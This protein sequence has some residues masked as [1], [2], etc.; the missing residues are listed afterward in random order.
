MDTY[1]NTQRTHPST[2]ASQPTSTTRKPGKRQRNAVQQP[3]TQQS[4]SR[5]KFDHFQ[6]EAIEDVEEEEEEEEE[7]E[8]A[9]VPRSMS[10]KDMYRRINEVKEGCCHRCHVIVLLTCQ[11]V[12]SSKRSSSITTIWSLYD[13]LNLNG[14]T[15][16]MS[17]PKARSL[18]VKTLLSTWISMFL[19][20]CLAADDC[21]KRME[22]ELEQLSRENDELRE[23]LQH[24]KPNRELV[25]QVDE[26]N[27][28]LT[29]ISEEKEALKKAGN[30]HYFQR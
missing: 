12:H 24:S 6:Q 23:K 4:A 3:A 28:E 13:S 2:Y 30:K 15:R 10:L 21:M 26:L 9:D 16:L 18:K 11:G 7:E 27:Q 19:T 14:F 25:N 8:Y 1:D 5:R 17:L 20:C 29:T 22:G